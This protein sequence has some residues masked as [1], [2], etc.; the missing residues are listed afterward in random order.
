MSKLWLSEDFDENYILTA[1]T[2]SWWNNKNETFEYFCTF[3]A[4]TAYLEPLVTCVYWL[5]ALSDYKTL[6]T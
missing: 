3:L 4:E 2:K 6:V 5:G 1:F